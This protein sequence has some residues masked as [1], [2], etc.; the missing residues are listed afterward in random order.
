MVGRDGRCHGGAR[1][2]RRR[3]RQRQRRAGPRR[4]PV[5]AVARHLELGRLHARDAAAVVHRAVRHRGGPHDARDERGDRGQA[6]AERRR[7]LRRC[8]RVGAVRAAAERCRPPRRDRPGARAQHV[9]AGAG[10]DGAADRSRLGVLRPVHVGHDRALL[11]RGPRVHAADE[12][13]RPAPAERG[14]RRQDHH[15]GDGPVAAAA[16]AE[17]AR[18]LRQ[19]HR[20]R[21]A[22]AG[23]GAP[24]L[25]EVDPPRVR[26][27]DVLQPPRERRGGTRR[28]VGRMV[29]LRDRGDAASQVRGA[30]R[31][32]RPLGRLD[33]DPRLLGEQGSRARLHQPRARPREPQAGRR[34]RALQGAEPRSDGAAR[35]GV[36]RA[37]PEPGHDAGRAPRGRAARRPR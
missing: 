29:Q 7:G 27:H 12:L 15:A 6:V 17:G 26:R 21:R 10:G 25:G 8:V 16:G 31:G 11:P 9:E 3:R 37:V 20:R 5:R 32:Q 35:P 13:E 36:V 34:A 30:H 14:R 2:V 23:A 33:G 24:H 18:V 4:R 28:G 19:H 22:R 1:C